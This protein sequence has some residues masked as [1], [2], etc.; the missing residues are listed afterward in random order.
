MNAVLMFEENA[1]V[2]LIALAMRAITRT[3]ILL[4]WQLLRAVGIA[5]TWW[6]PVA[7]A[8]VLV[9]IIGLCLACPFLPVGIAVI[10][11]YGWASM[12]RAKARIHAVSWNSEIN[13]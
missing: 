9:G 2:A 1:G 7:L 3:V 4:L 13:K 11:L 8:L 12:P 5:L 6:R 10:A